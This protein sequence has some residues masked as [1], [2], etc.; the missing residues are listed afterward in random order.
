MISEKSINILSHEA[1]KIARDNKFSFAPDEK[2]Q[3]RLSCGIRGE[4]HEAL[5]VLEQ[6][7]E[8]QEV[9]NNVLG[10]KLE[11]F[12]VEIADYVLRTLSYM[13]SR[14]M[15]YIEQED[16]LDKQDNYVMINLLYTVIDFAFIEQTPKR[17]S[18]AVHYALQIADFYCSDFEGVILQKMEFNRHRGFL[19]GKVL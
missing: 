15:E 14:G 19:H 10:G 9:W 11:G 16:T 18:S 7:R 12:L 1:F 4:L 5:E 13:R 6:G 8:E 2:T 3:A 17:F